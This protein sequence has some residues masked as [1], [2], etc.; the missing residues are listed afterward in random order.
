MGSACGIGDQTAGEETLFALAEGRSVSPS[1]L[2]SFGAS[3]R[4][5]GRARRLGLDFGLP[6]FKR[7]DRYQPLGGRIMKH[8]LTSDFVKAGIENVQKAVD[9][10]WSNARKVSVAAEE[11]ANSARDSTER[12][13]NIF[14]SFAAKSIASSLECSQ[15]ILRANSSEE[16]MRINADFVKSQTELLQAQSREIYDATTA[17]TQD[18]LKRFTR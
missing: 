17:S 18:T 14:G 3:L 12:L 4:D 8:D 15:A 7:F 2:L 9:D 10:F 6:T 13:A 1:A 5:Y 16:I 11:S